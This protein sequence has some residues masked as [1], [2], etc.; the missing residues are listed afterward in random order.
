MTRERQAGTKM[1]VESWK[2]RVWRSMV[3]TCLRCP[4]TSEGTSHVSESAL[5]L[6]ISREP[7][8]LENE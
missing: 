6:T 8:V 2:T 7:S 1:V 5:M 3:G 4:V